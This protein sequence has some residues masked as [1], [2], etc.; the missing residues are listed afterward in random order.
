[1]VKVLVA[2]ARTQGMRATDYF[3][4][5][6]GEI[7]HFGHVCA[8][9][10][11]PERLCGCGHAFAGLNS[12]RGSTTAEVREV[13]FT[14]RDLVEALRSSLAARGS[15]ASGADDEAERIIRLAAGLPVGIVVERR[16]GAVR[17][18]L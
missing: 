8:V 3:R 15:D 17:P 10:R 5:I 1:M 18:R 13:E 12:H 6:E 9:D 16:L 11:D 7:V 2:T 4:C 14:R